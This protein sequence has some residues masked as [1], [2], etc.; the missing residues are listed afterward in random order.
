MVGPWL[1]FW[2]D[3]EIGAKETT[4]ELS[5]ELFACAFRLSFA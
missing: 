1:K 5:D 3:A 4:S 2:R